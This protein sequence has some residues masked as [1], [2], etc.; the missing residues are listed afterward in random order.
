MLKI[1]HQG[2]LRWE[3][4]YK[5]RVLSA[6]LTTDRRDFGHVDGQAAA[7]VGSRWPRNVARG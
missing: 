5:E 4:G 6:E 1:R 3:G 2:D 7:L